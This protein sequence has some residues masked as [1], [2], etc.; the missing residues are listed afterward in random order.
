M[1]SNENDLALLKKRRATIQASCTR[2]KTFVSTVV[3]TTVTPAIKAQLEERRIKLEH[4]WSEYESIQTDIEL[5]DENEASHRAGFEEAFYTLSA[6]IRELSSTIQHARPPTPPSTRSSS[7]SELLSQVRLPKLNLPVF[8]GAYD[9]WFP[10]YDTFQSIIHRNTSLDDIQKLQ[11]L[12]AS[13]TG[14]AKNIISALEISA[15]NYE[16]AWRLLK[17]RYDN[18]RVIAQNHIRAI[19]ELPSMA[20]ENACELRQIVDGASRHISA[21]EALKRPTSQW[22]DLLIYILSNK[23]DPASM[24]EWQ[25]SL[26]STELPTYK[27]FSD[28]IA[29]RSQT[30]EATVKLGTSTSIKPSA[31][32]KPKSQTACVAAVKFKCVHCNEEHSIYYCP[33]FLAL[34]VPQRIA[35]IRKAKMCLNCLRSTAHSANKCTSGNC[36]TCKKKHN[37]LLHL[38]TPASEPSGGDEKSREGASTSTTSS[39]VVTH[40]STSGSRECVMLAT[41]VAYA[42]DSKGSQRPCRLLLDCGSQANFISSSFLN[43]LGIKAQVSDISISGINNTVSKASQ[44][45]RIKIQSRTNTFNTSIDCI[46]TEQVTERL[47]GFTLK[48]G[49]FEIP[50]N[51]E[52]ADPQFHV[53]S[54]IDILIGAEL[55]WQVLCIGHIKASTNH[56]TLQKTRFGWILAGRMTQGPNITRRVQ[57]MHALVSND[58]LNEQLTHFWQL[59]TIERAN[60]LTA[61]EN[62]C[63]QH[64]LDNV[65]RN[66]QGRYVVKLPFKDQVAAKIG[67]TREIALKRLRGLEK[68]LARDPNR[69]SQYTR[70]LDEYEAL[71]HMRQVSNTNDKEHEAFYLPH[72]CVFKSTAESSKIRVV[73]DASCKS[74]TGISLNDALRAGPVIQQD[75]F[76]ILIRFRMFIYALVADIIKMYRQILVHPS[77]TCYQRILWR[78]SPAND[79]R[80]Y[81]LCT[82]VHMVH[83][84][85]LF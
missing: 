42:F 79:V 45:A 17:N 60:N 49:T 62:I 50:R 46:V 71:G 6:R 67:D 30:L 72:H 73:F 61:D 76:S 55:F 48:R 5:Q 9:E 56:P 81:E 57:S 22:D 32:A 39:T 25:N 35:E 47:P 3:P 7:A 18:K 8:S 26:T 4:F 52:L 10:F 27:Q 64:F 63:E 68:R 83:H 12:R 20:R 19:M 21:L 54:D 36:K 65:S 16:A 58:Q 59:E 37:T 78:E 43:A 85:L 41:A 40:S 66:A 74:S 31:R 2:I 29:H 80:T 77:Q 44:T 51:I 69:K 14:D 82:V 33:K 84:L 15:A 23:L 75:L 28:F 13:L 24:R 1:S 34:T 53:S 38:D 70:F 11:Y